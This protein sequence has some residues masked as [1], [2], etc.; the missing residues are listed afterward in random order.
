MRPILRVE[1]LPIAE[2]ERVRPTFRGR[3]IESKKRRRFT[4]GDHMSG[5][6]EN[7]DSVHLQI[8][9]MLRTE[10]IT[11]ESAVNY[12][13]DTYNELVPGSDELSLTLFVEV[14]EKEMRERMLVELAGLEERIF[15]E[16]DG[17]RFPFRGKREGASDDRTTAVHYLKAKLSDDA[18]R[19]LKQ[20]RAKAAVVID[21]PRYATRT[22]LSEDAHGA[23]A[24]DLEG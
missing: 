14:P 22:D 5:L 2:Y 23:L 9:E 11:N 1:V 10:S 3:I 16:V 24:E 8:Q 13:V 7:R 12:E 15:A 4:L 17:A 19:S 20:R 18:A 6:F 21:H